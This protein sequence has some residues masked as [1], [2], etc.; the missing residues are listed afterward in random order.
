MDREE[1]HPTLAYEIRLLNRSG[2]LAM[3]YMTQCL[4]DEDARERVRRIADATYDR[5]EIWQESRKI[6]EG[7]RLPADIRRAEIF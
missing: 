4:N 1:R 3:I 5:F 6:D 7:Q 2:G